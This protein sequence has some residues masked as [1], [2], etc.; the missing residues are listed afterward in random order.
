MRDPCNQRAGNQFVMRRL[1]LHLLPVFT[2]FEHQTRTGKRA[3]QQNIDLVEGQP[4]FHQPI[5]RLETAAGI[6][7][8]KVDHFAIA[9]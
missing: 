9:P 5:K 4:V 7:G 2:G 6:A 1:I 3:V 8:K